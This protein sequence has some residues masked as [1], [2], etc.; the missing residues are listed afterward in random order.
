[1][2]TIKSIYTIFAYSNA[3]STASSVFIL[4]DSHT[5]RFYP[6]ISTLFYSLLYGFRIQRQVQ[7]LEG[8]S[9]DSTPHSHIKHLSQRKLPHRK[10]GNSQLAP[11][12]FPK[13]YSSEKFARFNTEN[14]IVPMPTVS[15]N[16]PLSI[17]QSF[18]SYR[19][20]IKH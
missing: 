19:I 5:L 11:H 16:F 2:Q 9:F 4:N 8:N 13:K 7:I 15:I 1:M 18:P 20:K 14:N 6:S 12:M 3:L 10:G 17:I